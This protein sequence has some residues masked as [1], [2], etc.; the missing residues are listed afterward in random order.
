[1]D[2]TAELLLPLLTVLSNATA[3]PSNQLLMREFRL[4]NRVVEML[5]DS[6]HWPRSTRVIL[7]QCIANMAVASDNM[8]SLLLSVDMS[9]LVILEAM[10]WIWKDIKTIFS[11][12]KMPTGNLKKLKP[13]SGNYCKSKK[14]TENL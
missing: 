3:Y 7:L 11:H 10:F 13:V 6:K 1:M 8:V 9:V 4:T 12:K 5:P 2:P 14:V